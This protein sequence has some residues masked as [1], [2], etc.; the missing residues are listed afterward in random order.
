MRPD[1]QCILLTAHSAGIAC[2]RCGLRN[3]CSLCKSACDLP[4]HPSSFSADNW[5]EGGLPDAWADPNGSLVN[6][7]VLQLANNTLSGP[8]NPKWATAGALPDLTELDLQVG[9]LLIRGG[10]IVGWAGKEDT[11]GQ[12]LLLLLSSWM[13]DS[14][15]VDLLKCC[16]CLL[17]PL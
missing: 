7:T 8:L 11:F 2:C 14:Q 5:L 12:C 9:G 13:A 6:L 1:A 15:A 4:A 3:V 17:R 16:A 10:L